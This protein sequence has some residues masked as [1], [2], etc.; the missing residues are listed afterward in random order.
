VSRAFQNAY[1][2]M[3]DIIAFLCD[4]VQRQVRAGEWLD[5]LR[6]EFKDIVDTIE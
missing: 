2:T 5:Q 4:V 6:S 1:Q 3:K